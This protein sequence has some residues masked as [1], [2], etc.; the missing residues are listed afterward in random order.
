M[1]SR[2]RSRTHDGKGTC[3]DAV[4][5]PHSSVVTSQ[6]RETREVRTSEDTETTTAAAACDAGD[7]VILVNRLRNARP[8]CFD[9]LLHVH[10]SHVLD[11]GR[12]ASVD[13]FLAA[14]PTKAAASGATNAGFAAAA[15]LRR[16]LKSGSLLLL[17]F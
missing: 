5:A 1:T 9:E 4:G 6:H 12:C 2:V 3:K 10:L 7:D 13:E 16:R 14:T 11:I 17:F 8:E 15:R